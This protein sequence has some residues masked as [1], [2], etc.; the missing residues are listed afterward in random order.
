[1]LLSGCGSMK[2]KTEKDVVSKY[3]KLEKFKSTGN[4]TLAYVKNS[5]IDR[6]AKYI[7]KELNIL[8]KDLELPINNYLIGLS[9]KRGISPD[10]TIQFYDRSE[11]DS[12]RA[13]K[14]NPVILTII[15]ETPVDLNIA[16]SMMLKHKGVWTKEEQEY[17]G[18][19]KVKDIVLVSYNF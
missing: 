8:L 9:N 7:G 17:F 4:D 15:W 3:Q 14:I 19:Q 11:I 6:K 1:M 13:K 2:I 5:I 12:K 16:D 10:I 18:K